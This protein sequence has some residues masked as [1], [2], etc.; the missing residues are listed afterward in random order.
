MTST[1]RLDSWKEIAAYL[2]RGVR[3]AQRWEATAQLP[4]HRI[5]TA[6]GSVFAFRAELDAWWRAT[7]LIRAA[8]ERRMPSATAPQPT[9]PPL[10][11]GPPSGSRERTSGTH[12]DGA[13]RVRSFLGGSLAM[14]PEFALAHANLAVYFFTLVVI[15]A[16]P[17]ADG[18][19]AARV[20]AQRAL[21]L[22]PTLA[23]ARALVALMRG[24]YDYEWEE[25]ARAFAAVGSLRH[26]VSP[27]VRCLYA[28]WHLSPLG[29]HAE[30]VSSLERA[31]ADDPENLLTRVHYA[32]ELEAAGRCDRGQAELEAVLAV[33]PAFGPALGFLGRNLAAM[34][35]LDDALSCAERTFAALPTHPN[36]VGFLAGMLRRTG[37]EE[38]GR[39]LLDGLGRQFSPGVARARAEAH[40][41][42]GEVD[43]AA[44]WIADAIS[45]R[46]P[47]V[48]LV[49]AGRV[50]ERV[51]TAPCWAALS[52]RLKL[53][54]A[55]AP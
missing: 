33:D 35:R 4:V 2:K 38:R 10:I 40:L 15:G 46:D 19:P 26:Q 48:W 14:D 18:M 3:T 11:E 50:G 28:A 9:A 34:G 13:M 20:S 29:C 8:V 1:G 27:A 41:V 23:E 31:L 47:G 22:E 25:A 43:A 53:P 39:L 30:A 36:A 54:A 52:S 32:L 49:L 16:L 12:A 51:R 5:P 44:G 37:S 17:P 55:T 21:S 42:C 7:G 24:V 6:R 45:G